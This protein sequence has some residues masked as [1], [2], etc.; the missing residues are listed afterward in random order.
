M[1]NKHFDIN[2]K[3]F[4]ITSEFPEVLDFLVANGLTKLSNPIMRRTVG[5]MITLKSALVSKGFDPELIEKQLIE[6]IEGARPSMASGL[7]EAFRSGGGSVKV[8]GILPCPIRVPLLER[9]EEWLDNNGGDFDYDLKAASMGTGWL[10]EKLRGLADESGL[11]DVFMSAGFGLF[12]DKELMGRFGDLGVYEDISGIETLNDCF[13]RGGGPALKDP[14]GR[15]TVLGV[16]PAVFAVNTQVLGDR[17]MPTS[18]ADLLHEDFRSSIALPTKDLDLFNAVLLNIYKE[19][20]EEGVKNLGRNMISRMHPAQMVKSD[21]RSA[22]GGKP[23]VTVMP[24]FFTHMME[25]NSNF[26]PVWPE[27]GAIVSPIFMLT[28]AGSADK[29]REFARFLF[30]PEV[31]RVMS[32]NGGFPSAHPDVDNGLSEEKKFLWTGWDY[33]YGNDIGE[34]IRLTESL[35]EQGTQGG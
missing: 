5:K 35:F 27:E 21:V 8:E 19:H 20:G 4:D 15:Y 34:L 25:K 23:A 33:I 13:S 6:V 12:F 10:E 9:L 32:V 29:T 24:Y 11:A 31:G 26:V 30:S 17:K 16:V 18:W 3:V 1:A 28:K 7:T 22:N 14:K 2:D